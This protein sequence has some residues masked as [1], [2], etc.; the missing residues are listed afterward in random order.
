MNQTPDTKPGSYY[1]TAI[2]G[3]RVAYLLGPFAWHL[4]ALELVGAAQAK[5]EELDPRA[6]WYAYGT[7]R[8]PDDVPKPHP[9]G[10]LNALLL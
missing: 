4:Q 5:A 6:F 9:V 3:K 7:A 2:D 1:V 8:I 10:K